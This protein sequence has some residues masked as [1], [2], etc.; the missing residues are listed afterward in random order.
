MEEKLNKLKEE[1]ELTQR[2]SIVDKTDE[3]D[4]GDYN[5]VEIPEK[6]KKM[7]ILFGKIGTIFHIILIIFYIATLFNAF[8]W[9]EYK[10]RDLGLMKDV[11]K[12]LHINETPQEHAAHAKKHGFTKLTKLGKEKDK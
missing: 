3:L 8:G 2:L 1:E 12:K 5:K 11:M 6:E 10:G 9:M 4:I 7:L